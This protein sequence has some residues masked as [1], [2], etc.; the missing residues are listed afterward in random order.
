MNTDVDN[1]IQKCDTNFPIHQDGQDNHARPY[2][3]G[4]VIH[5]SGPVHIIASEYREKSP[6]QKQT[7]P[8]PKEDA[9]EA[10]VKEGS[11]DVKD[12][13]PESKG[14]APDTKETISEA[15]ESTPEPKEL[16]PEPKSKSIL[17]VPTD[18]FT[19]DD[20]EDKTEVVTDIKEPKTEDTPPVSEKHSESLLIDL[21][22]PIEVTK[23]GDVKHS[24]D[25]F[26]REE[27]RAELELEEEKTM[28]LLEEAIEEESQ[29]DDREKSTVKVRVVLI[30][31]L[32]G[33]ETAKLIY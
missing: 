32:M 4:T 23:N 3:N 20:S 13:T 33:K 26:I 17:D 16:S 25:E 15:K 19:I 29:D 6:E 8:E 21:S 5:N 10:T 7:S 2:T 24:I 30:N 22:K 28:E 11:P 9:K 12:I 31:I 27:V 18:V 1:W 14:I